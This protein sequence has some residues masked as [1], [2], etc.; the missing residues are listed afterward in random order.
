[1]ADADNGG[2]P[3]VSEEVRAGGAVVVVVDDV[4]VVGTAVP[5]GEFVAISGVF[6][7]TMV[8]LVCTVVVGL[9]TAVAGGVVDG[10]LEGV[11]EVV[12]VDGI[13]TETLAGE[14]VAMFVCVLPAAS[15]TAN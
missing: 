13:D 15:S 5:L 1:M 6:D 14:P 10:L 3:S 9:P 4:V 12:V 2:V 11:V 8:T 7:E